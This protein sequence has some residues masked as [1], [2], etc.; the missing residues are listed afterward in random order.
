MFDHLV[1]P[2]SIPWYPRAYQTY[3]VMSRILSKTIPNSINSSA[4]PL[5]YNA[6]QH[7]ITDDYGG[8]ML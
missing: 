6:L 5:A 1:P 4:A 7:I 8:T 3:L 2:T